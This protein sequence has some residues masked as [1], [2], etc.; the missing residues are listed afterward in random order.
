MTT[1]H[2]HHATRPGAATV[3]RTVPSEL[4]QAPHPALARLAAGGRGRVHSLVLGP[5]QALGQVLAGPSAT[6]SS[7]D[8]PRPRR[9]LA[10]PDRRDHAP[11][12]RSVSSASSL[13]TGEYA[14]RAIRTTFT[15]VPRRGHVVLAKIRSRSGWS[16]L[17]GE[18]GRGRGR[19][20]RHRCAILTFGRRR[21]SA[22]AARTCCVSRPRR[23]G[24]WSGGASSALAAGWLTRSKIGG[25]ALLLGVMLVLAPR[26]QPVPGRVG[27]MLIAADAVLGR[28][29]DD[30]HPPAP[31]TRSAP[32]PRPGAGFVAVDAVT[33][34]SLHRGRLRPWV[35]SRRDA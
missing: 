20:E 11:P 12:A 28:R 22:G 1:V 15:L 2:D 5:V 34:C 6:A 18:R 14:P 21:T 7:G 26:P 8:A 32:P 31:P 17:R 30:Q 27:E 35:V 25:A 23:S 16:S 13:V 29:R 10:R 19:G 4:D 33:W 9:G 24:T 3:R